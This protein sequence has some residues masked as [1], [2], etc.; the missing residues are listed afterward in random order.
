MFR[1]LLFFLL[2][3]IFFPTPSY[4]VSFWE[5]TFA[6]V[7][8]TLLP[9][10]GYLYLGHYDKALTLGLTRWYLRTEADKN[11]QHDDFQQDSNDIYDFN[12]EEG[13]V[14]IYLTKET[15][16]YDYH[17]YTHLMLSSVSV[18]D[19]VD[20]GCEQNTDTY[21]HFLAPFRFDR[22][23]GNLSFWGPLAGEVVYLESDST[24]TT[25][26]LEDGFR[27]HELYQ[28]KLQREYLSG[29]GEELLFRGV[30]QK[31]LFRFFSGTFSKTVSR[32]SAIVLA[33]LVFGATHDG[34]GFNVDSQGAFLSGLYLGWLAQ[35]SD[36]VFDL[37]ESIAL[38]S[39]WNL[40][41]TYYEFAHARE[42]PLDKSQAGVRR[43]N[44]PLISWRY[45]F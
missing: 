37:T 10:T 21:W 19:L 33:S 40:V 23:G 28:L 45:R 7:S 36:G 42:A 11:Y 41:T 6:T 30:I 34:E 35:P 12:E 38:H 5:C 3:L 16:M 1:I 43:L 13:R 17:A 2:T 8:E 27:K 44:L 39:W 31:Q 26:H 25:Y 32:W 20:T 29:I 24:E 9:G 15:A 18:Y 14:D 4:S 22:F